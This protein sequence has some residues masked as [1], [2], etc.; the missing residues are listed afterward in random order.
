MDKKVQNYGTTFAVGE[1]IKRAAKYLIEG[2]ATALAAYVI[3]RA[4]GIKLGFE[5]VAMIAITASAIY[6]ILDIYMPSAGRTVRTGVGYG[7]GFGI[8]GFPATG[9]FG[10]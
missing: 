3:P 7:L 10:V 6:A 8:S 1:V 2:F 9:F 4:R 5:E